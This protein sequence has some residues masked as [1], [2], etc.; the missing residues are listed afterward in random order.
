MTLFVEPVG[1]RY[2]IK[3]VGHWQPWGFIAPPHFVFALYFLTVVVLWPPSLQLLLPCLPCHD[4][5]Y[6]FEL[7]S[8]ENSSFF[9]FHLD[10]YSDMATR[11]VTNIIFK[12]NSPILFLMPWWSRNWSPQPAVLMWKNNDQKTHPFKV[13][14]CENN[15]TIVFLNL[16]YS[17]KHD[18]FPSIIFI[19]DIIAFFLGLNSTP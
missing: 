14:A 8:R 16:S 7:Q 1:G 17:V 19:N 11:K 12:S 9:R 3:G 10:R 13:E 18:L 15:V 4:T 2:L 5:A 6:L